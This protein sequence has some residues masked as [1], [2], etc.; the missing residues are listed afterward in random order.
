VNY[1]GIVVGRE[2]QQ[3]CVV[4]ETRS[5]E[6]PIGLEATFYEPGSPAEVVEVVGMLGDV[7]VAIGSPQGPPFDERKLRACDA[8]LSRRGVNPRPLLD[9]GLALY[10]ALEEFGIFDPEVSDDAPVGADGDYEGLVQ[11]GTFHA[12][13]V[14]EVNPDAVFCALQGR[15]V[16]ARRHPLGILIRIDELVYDRVDDPGGD[17]WSR[18][19]E[20]IEAAAAA[21][22]AHRYAVGHAAWLGNP[23]EGVIVV[24]GSYPPAVYSSEGVVPPVPR[25]P[26]GRGQVPTDE[27]HYTPGPEHWVG[28]EPA[29]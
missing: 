22:C 3:L 25:A 27:P 28:D 14:F 21:L 15:R 8:A 17:L 26:L 12:A 5:D 23:D 13:R 4:T 20:E 6:P 10:D 1:C 9:A 7:V 24:P 2:L 29:P 19:I 18:R 16:P 11:E